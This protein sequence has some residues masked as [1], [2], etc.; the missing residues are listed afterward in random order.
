M[1]LSFVDVSSARDAYY[2]SCEHEKGGGLVVT[3]HEGC[4]REG[5]RSVYKYAVGFSKIGLILTLS[6]STTSLSRTM[7]KH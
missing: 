5:E 2:A 6:G 7:A 1:K 4:N 3:S